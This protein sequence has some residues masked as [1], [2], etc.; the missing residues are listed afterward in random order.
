MELLPFMYWPDAT[1]DKAAVQANK[2]FSTFS[3]Y[4]TKAVDSGTV[5]ILK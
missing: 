2:S 4:G 3:E 5:E 1:I